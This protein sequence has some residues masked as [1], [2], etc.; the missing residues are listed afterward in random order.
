MG[1][2]HLVHAAGS[3]GLAAPTTTAGRPPGATFTLT[4]D[5]HDVVGEVWGTGPTVYLV[6][7]WAGQRGQ[8]TP[9]VAP[10]VARG[11][12]VVAFDAP[13]HG[14]SGPGAF[15]P[16][17]SSIVEF[18]NALTR[19]VAE[20]GPAQAIVAHS[21]GATAAA[22]ALCDGLRARRLVMLAPMASPLSYARSSRR[23]WASARGPSA[24]W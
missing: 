17:S 19:V 23:C 10:L 6:H 2:A 11:Y 20:H 4:V 13:S 21:M 14:E 18:A 12:R 5:G 9:F 16:R 7:G 8:L 15:G 22:V 24:G 1:G 3:E